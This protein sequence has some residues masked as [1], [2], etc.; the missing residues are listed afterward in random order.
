MR[1]EDTQSF[2]GHNWWLWNCLKQKVARPNIFNY[3]YCTLRVNYIQRATRPLDRKT[4]S[5][6][7]DRVMG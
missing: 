3:L 7:S 6:S 4:T 2:Q 5:K 1:T